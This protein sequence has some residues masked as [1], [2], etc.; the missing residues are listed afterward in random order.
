LLTGQSGTGKEVV[1][2]FIHAASPR[3][4]KPFV[5]V[6]CGAIPENLIE[7]HLFGHERGSF[8]GATER[9]IGRF[10]AA[11]TGTLLLDEISEMP[12]PLQ[13]RLLRVLQEREIHRVGGHQPITIDVRIVATTNRDLR[14][15][16]RDGEFREDLYYR[17]NVFPLHLPPLHQRLEDME[18]LCHAILST[19]STRFERS[20]PTISTAAMT[21]LT[22]WH[23]PGNVRELHNVLE[24]ALILD[25]ADVIEPQHILL[26]ED[27]VRPRMQANVAPSVLEAGLSLADL[28]QD[29]IIQ[30]LEAC[31]GNRTRAASQ[32][33][34]SIRTLRN[35]LRDYR[36]RGVVVP[37]PARG[38]ATTPRSLQPVATQGGN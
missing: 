34:I 30:V 17:L 6:N 15:M 38:V 36:A 14:Q 33:G 23:W 1:A 9:R 7:S 21:R 22:T 31:Q 32:L 12:L 18:G 35:R 13:T 10:E 5:A 11:H 27:V 16:V 4:A 8:S 2:R 25:P 28:E 20:A 24:R 19:L 3:A 37:I 26:D 29:T